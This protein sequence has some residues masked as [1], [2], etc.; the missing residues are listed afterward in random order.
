MR[1]RP[2]RASR[3]GGAWR[4]ARPSSHHAVRPLRI[5]PLSKAQPAMEIRNASRCAITK[6]DALT[7]RI[8]M[9][10]MTPSVSS[11]NSR[12]RWV[13]WLVAAAAGLGVSGIVAGVERVPARA[14][15]HRVRVVDREAGAHQAV[16]VVD[17]A[18]ADVGGA[19]VVDDDVNAVL[20]DG[21]VLGAAHVVEGHAVLHAGAATAAD[22][23]SERQLR[24]A[25]L[26]EELLETR[27]R[28][29][30]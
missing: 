3:A 24:V 12:R 13:R 15:M 16:D 2:S 14:R 21:D 17:L 27:L 30:G 26:G 19:E 28:F 20:V 23:D 6:A 25:L 7:A 1:R 29:R 9:G 8:P 5:R 22:E 11:T 18:A 10:V 4:L